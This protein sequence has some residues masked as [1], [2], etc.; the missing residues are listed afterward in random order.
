MPSGGARPNGGQRRSKPR[1]VVKPSDFFP[2]GPFQTS[3]EFAMAVINDPEVLLT[4][5]IRVAIAAMPFQHAKVEVETGKKRDAESAAKAAATG[6]FS[7]PPQPR[8]VVN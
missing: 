6:K 8:Q 1:S 7:T 5:K 3:L 4:D 2:H